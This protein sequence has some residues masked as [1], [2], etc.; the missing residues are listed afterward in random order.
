M[1]QP[2]CYKLAFLAACFAT[3][4][5]LGVARAR[6]LATPELRTPPR[7]HQQLATV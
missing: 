3:G 6:A 7:A 1:H 4:F 2:S 5:W